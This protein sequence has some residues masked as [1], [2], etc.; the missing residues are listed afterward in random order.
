MPYRR[1]WNKPVHK[2]SEPCNA[3]RRMDGVKQSNGPKFE[4]AESPLHCPPAGLEKKP[5]LVV[6]NNSPPAS[7]FLP[8]LA[9]RGRAKASRPPTKVLM[10]IL[11]R[12]GKF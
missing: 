7:N 1:T 9:P 2:N 12:K 8:L 5:R 4:L 6:Q 10:M 11:R 3:K